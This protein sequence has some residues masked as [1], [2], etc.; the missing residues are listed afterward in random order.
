MG[1]LKFRTYHQ[2]EG[3]DVS[4]LG[5]Q[6][7][8]QRGRVAE[9][10]AR[11][12]RVVAVMSGKGGVGKSHVTAGI[13]LAAAERSRRIGV[14]D[15][16]LAGPTTARMLGARGP[17]VVAADGVRPA[18]GLHG[19]TVF[20]TDLLLEEGAP[21]RWKGESNEPFVWRGTLEAGALREFLADVVWGE[22]DLLLIDLPPGTSR[23]QD[24]AELV[25]NLGGVIAVTI[26]TDESFQAVSRAMRA[27]RDADLPLVGVVENMAGY[28][29]SSCG[30]I[31]PLFPGDAGDRLA[32]DF[33]VPLLARIPFAAS[34]GPPQRLTA[35][36]D[37]VLP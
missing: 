27:A 17:L 21:L 31:R 3:G 22:L 13:A 18:T 7:G 5:G 35:L 24:L 19:L 34:E 12:N 4:D 26:P 8:R 20:S 9:R 33:A 30:A 25:P 10:L 32:R 36:A 6:V 29:C 37:V 16:D 28:R 15:A 14:L 2:V 23:L 11:V 1:S